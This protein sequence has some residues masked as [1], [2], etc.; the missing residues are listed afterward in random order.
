MAFIA[1]E[2]DHAAEVAFPS[3]SAAARPRGNRVEA[4][5]E[6]SATQRSKGQ[7]RCGPSLLTK[8]NRGTSYLLAWRQTVSVCGSDAGRTASNTARPR[9]RGRA[10][11]ALDLDG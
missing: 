7:R 6:S 2:V 3:R 8:Q 4:V 10:G 1:N 9:R 5:A 11:L